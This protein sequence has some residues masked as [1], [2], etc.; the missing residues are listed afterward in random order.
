MKNILVIF[1]AAEV[2]SDSTNSV[3]RLTAAVIKFLEEKNNIIFFTFDPNYQDIQ[4]KTKPR[5]VQI[6][7]GQRIKK[8][9]VNIFYKHKKI[10]D[11]Q[12]TRQAIRNAAIDTQKKIDYIIV[13]SLD[14]VS[15]LRKNFPG[16]KILY[17]IH[18]ISAICKKE[19]LYNVNLADY[20]LSPS[21]TTY[22]LLL[23]KLQPVPLTAEFCFMPNWCEEVFMQKDDIL[24]RSIKEKYN[25]RQDSMVFI[26]SG[27]DLKL[28]GKFIVE[29]AIKKLAEE[30]N[31]EILFFF[32]GS[33]VD[34]HEEQIKNIRIV[35][36]GLLEPAVLAAYLHVANFGFLPSLAYDHCPLSLL[37]MI[38]CDV[39]PI[40]SDM[41]GIKEI[42]GPAYPYLINEPHEV[43][44]WKA[45]MLQVLAMNET[46]RIFQSNMLKE[47]V[48]KI[49]TK[50]A[51]MDTLSEIINSLE[52]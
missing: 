39:L 10:R 33:T 19:Y 16:A 7:K 52:A 35:H 29:K 34:S 15:F 38:S 21:R 36:L 4:V 8:R 43:N 11:F 18:N 46:E 17:W 51:A 44:S 31:S 40:A 37:E 42:S 48:E 22:H 9:L 20:F 32:A 25:I 26:F 13:L 28:K 30:T 14:D 24:I 1:Y 23:Q 45:A 49:Y 50:K 47:R 3:A 41:G 27:S 12:L 2:K 6:T 5:F